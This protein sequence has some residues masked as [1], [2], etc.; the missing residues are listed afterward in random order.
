MQ[1]LMG[2][3]DG[4]ICYNAQIETHSTMTSEDKQISHCWG[5]LSK[6][7]IIMSLVSVREKKET[8][9]C[10]ERLCC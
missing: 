2:E 6:A 1:A 7:D 10:M 9:G 5:S 3:G 4:A 8:N